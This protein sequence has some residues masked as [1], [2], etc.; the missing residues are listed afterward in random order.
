MARN[1]DLEAA[2]TADP[3]DDQLYRVY[4]DWLEEKGDLRAQLIRAQLAEDPDNAAPDLL[5]DHAEELLGP[6][7]KFATALHWRWGFVDW[8]NVSER[9]R[10][11]AGPCLH[12]LLAHP[13]GVFL[14]S[15]EIYTHQPTAVI[16]SLAKAPPTLRYLRFFSPSKT[17]SLRGIGHVFPRLKKLVLDGMFEL[18]EPLELPLADEL[19]IEL[20]ALS[21]KSAGILAKAN[22]PLLQGLTIGLAKTVDTRA[23]LAPL[24]ARELPSLDY[25]ALTDARELDELCEL[26]VTAPFAPQLKGLELE[27]TLGRRGVEALRDSDRLSSLKDI[28]VKADIDRGLLATLHRPGRKVERYDPSVE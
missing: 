6:L 22:L 10:L 8:A 13:V 20:D 27:G 7:A 21:A 25:L 4:A 19:A 5:E 3:E 2:I 17:A 18:V 24:F 9:T 1:P 11:E 15:L 26:L 28:S 16:E 14:R 23:K 12:I